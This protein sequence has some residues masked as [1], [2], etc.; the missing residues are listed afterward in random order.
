MAQQR[1]EGESWEARRPT[2]GE[3][4]EKKEVDTSVRW[5]GIS[6]RR[7][8]FRLGGPPEESEFFYVAQAKGQ[9]DA[10]DVVRSHPPCS[11][12]PAVDRP[13][14][15]VTLFGEVGDGDPVPLPE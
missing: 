1:G 7:C 12:Q 13:T 3:E 8:L 9:G 14:G 6:W 11:T 15:H 4:V 2:G 10:V 5:R